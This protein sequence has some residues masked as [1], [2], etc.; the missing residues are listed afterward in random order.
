MDGHS[1]RSDRYSVVV[2][3]AESRT[4]VALSGQIDLL[5]LD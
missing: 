5:A 3:R 4:D 1:E 2:T